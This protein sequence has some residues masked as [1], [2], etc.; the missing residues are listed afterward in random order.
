MRSALKPLFLIST[1]IN[2]LK[3]QMYYCASKKLEYQVF[4][5]EMQKMTLGLDKFTAETQVLL[6]ESEDM[7]LDS[8]DEVLARY[9]KNVAD[10][11]G[12]LEHHV[13]GGKQAKARYTAIVDAK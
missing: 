13:L 5:D 2:T 7:T 6:A 10:A 4:V 9:D 3:A 11:L 8:P 12:S 1:E